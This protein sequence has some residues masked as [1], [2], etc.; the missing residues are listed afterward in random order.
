MRKTK[1]IFF[2]RINTFEDEILRD[3]HKS[4][5]KLKENLKN[6]FYGV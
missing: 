1:V 4:I 6:K 3:S 5:F 2:N